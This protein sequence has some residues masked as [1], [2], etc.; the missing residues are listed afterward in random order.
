[1]GLLF[2]VGP[3]RFEP[4]PREDAEGSRRVFEYYEMHE[5]GDDADYL[6]LYFNDGCNARIHHSCVTQSLR[7]WVDDLPSGTRMIIYKHPQSR[8][9]IEI[10]VD[11]VVILDMDT[12][13]SLMKKESN[14]FAIMGIFFFAGAVFLGV[15]GTVKFI[16]ERRSE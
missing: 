9:V 5:A 6:Y 8:D 16:R 2:T 1:M 12:A 4:V 3:F 10:I 13:Q 15:Y 14:G 7:N 11:D